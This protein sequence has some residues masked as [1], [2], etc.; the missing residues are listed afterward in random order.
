MTDRLP[1]RLACV[2]WALLLATAV[3]TIGR[4][5]DL[6][7]LEDIAMKAA[8]KRVAASVVRIET[9]GGLERVG[10]L[11]VGTGPTSGT[12]VSKDGYIV[13][14]A[15]N[16][17]QKP[18]SI[19][20]T[21]PSGKRVAA[22]ITARDHARMLVLLK[23]ATDE[24]LPV[25]EAVA[26]KEMVVGQWS[27]AVGRAFDRENVNLSVGVLSATNRIWGKAVQTDAKVSPSN[28]GGPLVDI[29][30]RV[31]GVLV[32]LSPNATGEVAGAEWYDSGIGFAVPLDEILT[33]LDRMKMGEDLK[34]GILG[35]SL[36]RGDMYALPAVVAACPA[37]SPAAKAGLKPGDEV[38]EVDGA[39]I[40]SQ[41]Q[42]KHALGRRY[43]G[44]P[45]SIVVLRGDERL[46]K[47][48][49]LVDQLVPYEH[50]FLGILPLR[51]AGGVDVRHVFAG[52]PASDAGLQPGDGLVSINDTAVT[53]ITQAQDLIAQFEPAQQVRV[54]VKRGGAI[55]NLEITLGHLPLEISDSLPPARAA[56]EPKAEQRPPVGVI[57]VKIPEEKN[58][59]IA[60]I[61]ESYDPRQSYGLVVWL[62]APD[63]FDQD[64]LLATW[65]QHCEDNDLILL[66]PRSA[67]PKKWEPT[68]ADF[69]RKVIDDIRDDYNIDPRRVVTHGYQAGGAMAYIVAFDQTELV[70][71]V[72]AIDSGLPRRMT[73]PANDPLKRLAVYTTHAAKSSVSAQVQA[74]AKR[75]SDMKYPVTAKDLGE[76]ARYLSAEE[77]A[78]LVRW[79]DTLDRI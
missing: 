69:I 73:V 44:D 76:A 56:N 30:G 24:D 48:V 66:A 18:T 68:E 70:R 31:L 77:I 50:P 1:V 40:A 54:Q 34:S 12:I 79:I 62:H 6:H 33:Q 78:E 74:A 72:A 63:G 17:V 36:K 4:S 55:E 27:L 15:F 14:S 8:A 35:I 10:K 57:D 75:L 59:C 60:Y 3:T 53:D 65:K 42:L 41:S 25:P 26:R 39:K 23:V 11:L 38:V 2:T 19:L 20:V 43:A 58:D 52:S 61:P 29:R 21:L 45:V 7:E 71:G 49:E 67:D 9:F 46:S 22:E 51:D 37:N 32:P 28:Y 47:T 13:S 16:F 64:A 5:Q